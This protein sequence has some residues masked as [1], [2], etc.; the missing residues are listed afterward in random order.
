MLTAVHTGE[1]Q[2][3]KEYTSIWINLLKPLL[4]VYTA[5]V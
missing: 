5:S 1:C 3:N 4:F 2:V